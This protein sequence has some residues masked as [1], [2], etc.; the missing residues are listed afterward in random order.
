MLVM[1]VVRK[2]KG[3]T[4]AELG[5]KCGIAEVQINAIE[6]KRVFPWEG[7]KARISDALEWER[8]PS[9]LFQDVRV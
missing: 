3:M 2:D 8:D 4:Q 5:R 9:E 1:T 6:N 7:W